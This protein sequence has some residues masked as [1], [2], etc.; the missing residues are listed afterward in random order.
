ACRISFSFC[1]TTVGGERYVTDSLKQKEKEILHAEEN[2]LAREQE[3]F[4]ALVATVLDDAVAL[5]QTA[6]ALAELDVLAGWA[7]IAREWDFCQPTLDE[8]E[9][10]EIAEGRHPVVEQMLK[11]PDA[12]TARGASQAF[13]PNDT[14]LA[15]DDA[16][17]ALITG[18]NMAGKSTY[19]RQVALITLL[20][21]IG[22]WVPAKSC[23]G[24]LV[25]R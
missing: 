15:C 18:P 5:A 14:L 4:A 24:G 25:D 19:I 17:L 10:L 3:L 1:L 16:Q 20:A 13:V 23:R 6:D 7:V 12:A 2:S 21:Q 8:G 9:V 11:S 22:C